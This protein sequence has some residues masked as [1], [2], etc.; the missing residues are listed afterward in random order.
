LPRRDWFVSAVN[1]NNALTA[2]QGGGTEESPWQTI[3]Q[4]LG[5]LAPLT[6]ES[7]PVRVLLD[8][9]SNF[10]DAGL[11]AIALYA[12]QVAFLPFMTLAPA[13]AQGGPVHLRPAAPGG[14]PVIQGAAGAV[15]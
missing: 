15:L 11:G 1:G 2:L 3:G 12:E 6:R 9:T 10:N 13:N 5:T 4:A 14:T 7:F 8:D